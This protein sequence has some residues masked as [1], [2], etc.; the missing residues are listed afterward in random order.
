[1][2]LLSSPVAL[3]DYV[4][5]KQIEAAKARAEKAAEKTD[6]KKNRHRHGHQVGHGAVD[7]VQQRGLERIAR[8]HMAPLPTR[9]ANR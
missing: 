7:D 9:S 1:M 4:R 6:G 5:E 8:A 2:S 3:T